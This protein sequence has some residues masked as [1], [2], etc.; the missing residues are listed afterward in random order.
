MSSQVLIVTGGSR[1]IGAATV[2]LAADRGWTVC[3][4][5]LRQAEE[6][7]ALARATYD[8]CKAELQ[9]RP[10]D[11]ETQLPTAFGAAMEVLG[12]VLAARGAELRYLPAYSPDLNPIELA[13]AKLKATLRAAA[14]REWDELLR[15]TAAALTTFTPKECTGFLRHAR[16]ATT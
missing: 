5:Y 4:S 11:Q 16:Y 13:F 12:Q 3:F 6:A 8:L 9:R 1:G 10:M 14:A 7:E 2:R 15:A